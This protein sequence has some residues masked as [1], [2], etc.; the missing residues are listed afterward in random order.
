LGLWPLLFL[1]FLGFLEVWR[2]HLGHF[3]TAL[4]LWISGVSDFLSF[5][6]VCT[7]IF[8]NNYGVI[9][10]KVNIIAHCWIKDLS[11]DEHSGALRS[12]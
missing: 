5:G 12:V 8:Q 1:G 6:E 4:F 9:I 3:S 7:G 11:T 10:L 2:F